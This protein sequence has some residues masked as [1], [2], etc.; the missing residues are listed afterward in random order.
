[1]R[2]ADDSLEAIRDRWRYPACIPGVEPLAVERIV[3][4]GGKTGNVAGVRCVW[5]MKILSKTHGCSAIAAAERDGF[6]VARRPLVSDQRPVARA[7]S[8]APLANHL[9]PNPG[10]GGDSGS[11]RLRN[12]P[13]VLLF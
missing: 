2:T 13:G 8:R 11:Q 3:R 9:R 10:R 12:P 1:M 4:G 7:L 6:A 5:S